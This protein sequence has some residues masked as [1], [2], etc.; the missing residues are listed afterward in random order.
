[1]VTID[2]GGTVTVARLDIAAW[3]PKRA[4]LQTASGETLPILKDA[5]MTPDMG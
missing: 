2:T 4:T 3:L 5:F 1:L